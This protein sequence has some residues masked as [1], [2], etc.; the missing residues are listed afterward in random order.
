MQSSLYECVSHICIQHSM[1]FSI[2][3]LDLSLLDLRF[4]LA[5]L[6]VHETVA[7]GTHEFYV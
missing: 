2:N 5:G 3:L 7:F 6:D 1:Q 4:F